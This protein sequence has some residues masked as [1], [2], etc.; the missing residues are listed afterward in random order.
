MG[1]DFVVECK[2]GKESIVDMA[3]A[4]SLRNSD[5]DS[6][7]KAFSLLVPGW[8]ER[9]Q[10]EHLTSRKIQNLVRV[11]QHGETIGSWS[12]RD[13]LLYF[14]GRIYLDEESPSLKVIIEQFHGSKHEGFHK[15][16][17]RIQANFY[18]KGLRKDVQRFIRE[19]DVCQ[20]HIVKNL[21]PAVVLQHLPIP[22]R[23]WEDIS[24]YFI[25]ELP[26]LKGKTT[27]LVVV[28]CLSK[29]A[30][31]VAPSHPCSAED[32]TQVLFDQICRLHGMPRSIVC[33]RD[34]IFANAF[35]KELFRLNGTE[36][37]F[38]SRYHTQTDGPT[39]VVN[40]TL[41]MY[42]RY[43]SGSHPKGWSNWLSWAEFCYNT[44][45]H[46][47]TK[48]TPFKAVYGKKPPFLTPYVSGTAKLESVEQLLLA[49][50]HVVK[51]AREN[52]AAAL[53]RMKTIYDSKH[54]EREFVTGDLVYLKLQAY[55]KTSVAT[56][57]VYKLSSRYYGPFRVLEKIESVAYKLELPTESKIHPVFHVSVLQKH[58]GD[59]L[60]DVQARVPVQI[61]DFLE[62]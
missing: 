39:E 38:S 9:I 5:V 35:Q 43:F 36:F 10:E 58:V 29:Y 56:R 26:S 8:L 57:S 59:D 30:H 40:K 7:L 52:I 24:M 4:L 47:T 53:N 42:L 44:S 48:M 19:C 54:R 3:D 51:D 55:C 31:F 34:P 2:K 27:I 60:I 18:F 14:K 28:D 22:N 20:K 13:G 61:D 17:H 45:L 62:V 49:R 11:V 25:D 33:D 50:D 15:T 41:E 1:F 6:S 12:F 16:L 32:I 23:I 37:N 21:S 46:F